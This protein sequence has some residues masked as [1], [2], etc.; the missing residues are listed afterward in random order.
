MKLTRW[1][2][3]FRWALA[4][5]AAHLGWVAHG[6]EAK[7]QVGLKLVATNLVSPTVLTSFPGHAGRLLIADQVGLVHSVRADG[8]MDSMPVRDL[9]SKLTKLEQGF[10]ER[11]LLGM[12]FHPKFAENQRLYVYYS[13]PRRQSL[14]AIL[15]GSRPPPRHRSAPSHAPGQCAHRSP[16]P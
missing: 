3:F 9:R 13:A 8:T 12:A 7:L 4:A 16:A 1:T 15:R 6:A 14:A 5:A 2:F 11:G 10:D